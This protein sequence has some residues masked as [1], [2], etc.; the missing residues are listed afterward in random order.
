MESNL[1]CSI[2]LNNSLDNNAQ[3]EKMFTC[4]N[5]FFHKKCFYKANYHKSC[6]SC[7]LCNQ[8]TYDR[9][10]KR[11]YKISEMNQEILNQFKL[12]KKI[13]ENTN[14]NKNDFILSGS[15]A[16]YIFQL[17][18]NK[19]P[20]WKYNDIDI[21]YSDNNTFK[22]ESKSIIDS[23]LVI[24]NKEYNNKYKYKNTTSHIKQVNKIDVFN[25]DKVESNSESN[26]ESITLKKYIS[27]DFI[28]VKYNKLYSVVESFDLDCCKIYIK[29]IDEFIELY[30]H[31]DVYVDS[32]K[33][34]SNVTQDRI[35]KYKERGF[36]C[37]KFD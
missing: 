13:I 20:K 8:K 9:Y 21:Y 14:I 12:I 17:F 26:S 33:L 18:C 22:L 32:F 35:I 1:C 29:I 19:N 3:I 34:I 27:F 4:C 28:K 11:T 10:E 30:I 37:E 23:K 31:N 15:F 7:P 5:H 2:C 6:V 16:V 24:K 36:N 25:L